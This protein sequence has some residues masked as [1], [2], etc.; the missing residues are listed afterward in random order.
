[1]SIV[2]VSLEKELVSINLYLSYDIGYNIHSTKK[3]QKM[4]TL[5]AILIIAA[6]VVI[7]ELGHAVCGWISGVKMKE[8]S[9][10][11]GPGLKI[12]LPENKYIGT[13]ILSPLLI[14]GYVL[15]D[16]EQ[17][18][19]IAKW[20][21]ILF[22]LGGV[23]ANAAL[24]SLILLLLGYPALKAIFGPFIITFIFP[25]LLGKFLILGF[26]E[27]GGIMG[28]IGIVSQLSGDF[29][30]LF[31]ANISLSLAALNILPI[32]PLDGGKIMCALILEPLFGKA[33]AKKMEGVL[34]ILGIALFLTLLI[35]ATS[36]D[37][38]PKTPTGK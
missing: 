11:I 3:E 26:P 1:M 23:L 28:P 7:H 8:F 15:P 9:V 22:Y 18:D 34:S 32:P 38:A 27:G 16:K 10:G 20:R 6:L 33:R 21:R 25:F 12:D 17:L 36:V 4:G 5:T 30:P 13:L 31:I 35:Y 2:G 19:A 37:I 29:N 24:A 14:G